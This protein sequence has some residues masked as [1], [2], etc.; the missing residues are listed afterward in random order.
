MGARRRIGWCRLAVLVGVAVGLLILRPA[1]MSA[2]KRTVPAGSD[3]Q[4]ALD[5]AQPGDIVELAPG[6]VYSGNFVLPLKGQGSAFITVR[7]AP[8]PA[9][10]R[11]GERIQ[12]SHA[13]LLAKLRS[14]NGRPALAT[15]PRAHHWRLELLEFQS[16][17]GGSGDIMTLGDG[18]RAQN[19]LDQVP[20]DL[21]VDRC[22]VH[23]DVEAGQKRG[24]ALNT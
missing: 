14:P 11:E 24:I 15:A 12:P 6:A 23:G 16:N 3:L 7:S 1:G 8:D 18:S 10:P 5:A 4:A 19:A 17:A 13:P 20:H 22:Y 2:A 9:L 21:I